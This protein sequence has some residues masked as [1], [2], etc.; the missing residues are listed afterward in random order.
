[1]FKKWLMI[2][3]ASQQ[4]IYALSLLGKDQNKLNQQESLHF[5]HGKSPHKYRNHSNQ[6]IANNLIILPAFPLAH[7]SQVDWWLPA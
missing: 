6:S 2:V 4:E 1:M 7:E 3:E 5:K